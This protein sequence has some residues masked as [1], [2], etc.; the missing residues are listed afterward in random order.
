MAESADVKK[1]ASAGPL[2][3]YV[4]ESARPLTSLVFVAP[5]LVVYEGGVLLLGQQAMRNGADV[6]LRRLLD[7]IGFGQYLLLPIVSVAILLAWHHMRRDR[8]QVSPKV[9]ALMA[10]EVVA[11]A[12]LLSFVGRLQA[13]YILEVGAAADPPAEIAR[14]LAL[15]VAYCGAGIYEELLF[16]LMLLP[17]IAGVARWCGAD[18]N[19][20]WAIGVV[21]NSLLF[22][23]AHY[24]FVAAGG[25]PFTLA[26]FV[27]RVLAGVFFSV[28]FIYRGFGIAAGSHA[29]YD[30]MAKLVRF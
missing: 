10:A 24:D 2:A 11:L 1:P 3:A 29:I 17:A 21:L 5:L 22:S 13:Q 4:A 12:V 23:L 8:W 25:Y 7:L 16:R 28:L 20:S 9:L 27:F 15:A 6:W 26:S 30:I 18:W 14:P 19:M